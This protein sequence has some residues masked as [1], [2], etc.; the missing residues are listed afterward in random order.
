MHFLKKIVESPV[1]KDPAKNFMSVHRH[2]YRYSRGDFGGPI[3]KVTRTKS[4]IT[5]KG[6]HEYEDL[7]QEVVSNTIPSGENID[8]R[9]T[10]IT[11]REVSDIIANLGFN[12]HV[13]RSTGQTKNYKADISDSASKEDII[14][15]IQTFREH[16]YFLLSFNVNP[17][18][19][20]TTKRK[21]P[22]P[23]K[24]EVDDISK[25]IQFCIG[26]I[27]NAEK[28][29]AL[30]INSALSDFKSNISENW[31][32]IT[33]FNAYKINEIEIPKN[34]RNSTLLRIMAIRKGILNRSVDIDG[35]L[36]ENQISIVV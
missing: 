18:C 27:K 1:L 32:K 29:C 33:I 31:K 13:K 4:K 30:L 36:F 22:Q 14:K 8:I 28:N 5:L 6:S 20:V 3:L 34:I 9:A 23:S 2:F 26:V 25:K 19:K 11:G 17:T 16:S 7:I 21:I 35:D 10:L 24:K 15:C 12:W